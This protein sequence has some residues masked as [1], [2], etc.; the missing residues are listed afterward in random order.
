MPEHIP[1]HAA[2]KGK[3]PEPFCTCDY[4]EHRDHHEVLRTFEHRG[5]A[6][7]LELLEVAGLYGD[8]ADFPA[9]LIAPV[10]WP[11]FVAQ[12]NWRDP[13]LVHQLVAHVSG[14]IEARWELQELRRA[15]LEIGNVV[16]ALQDSDLPRRGAAGRRSKQWLRA[17]GQD[18]AMK[19]RRAP[20]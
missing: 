6:G 7:V 10:D 12:H 16:E 20:R 18:E 17:D 3:A 2:G 1:A 4:N 14:Y 13:A 5:L 15:L 8:D 11:D 19:W 9:N